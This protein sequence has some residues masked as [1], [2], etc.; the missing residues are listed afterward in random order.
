MEM[1]SKL[2]ELLWRHRLQDVDLLFEQSLD[3]VYAAKPLGGRGC[4][5]TVEREHGG[6]QLVQDLF[7]PQLVNLMDDD[8]EHL[9]VMRRPRERLLQG[10]E[11]VN[12]KIGSV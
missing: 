5:V 7:E 9:V 2:I 3:R 6:V 12:F 8:E 10:E 1:V 4:V 11:L